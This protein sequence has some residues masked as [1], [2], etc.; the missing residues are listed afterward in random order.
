[1]RKNV[2]LCSSFHVHLC[3]IWWIP[4]LWEKYCR[5]LYAI[6]SSLSISVSVSIFFKFTVLC[7]LIQCIKTLISLIECSCLCCTKF[8]CVHSGFLH[9][10]TSWY[11]IIVIMTLKR[12]KIKKCMFIEKCTQFGRLLD[13][14]LFHRRWRRY[15]AVLGIFW[16]EL[17]GK[18]GFNT[19]LQ[20]WKWW[21]YKLLPLTI[22][23]LHVIGKKNGAIIDC[24]AKSLDVA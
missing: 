13:E 11:C 21:W 23:K 19:C 15:K 16:N 14:W 18:V 9:F 22:L 4:V 1:M 10:L 2:S 24:I 3:L 20:N 7:C 12:S 6:Q 8:V 17:S 5:L